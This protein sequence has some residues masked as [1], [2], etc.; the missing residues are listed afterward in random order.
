MRPLLRIVKP[1]TTSRVGLRALLPGDFSSIRWFGRGPH[2]NYPDRKA[3]TL[4][5]VHASTVPEQLTPYIRPGECGAKVDVRWLEISRPRRSQPL[6]SLVPVARQPA[7]LFAV[8]GDSGA[9]AGVG[10]GKAPGRNELKTGEDEQQQQQRQEGLFAFSALSHL[11]EDLAGVMHPEQLAPRPFTAVSL[12]HRIMGVGG[13]DSWSACVHDEF[14]VRPGRFKFSFA[15][16]PYWRMSEAVGGGEIGVKAA[17][18]GVETGSEGQVIG[19]QAGECWRTLRDG[20]GK[21][22]SPR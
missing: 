21:G 11:A 10:G 16:A 9:C 17:A 15:M 4:V 14:L 6:P 22:L 7:V 8:P 13:D 20:R 18:P 1:T 12:D 2:E 19:G 3:S 5:A